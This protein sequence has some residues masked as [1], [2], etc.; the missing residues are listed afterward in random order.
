MRGVALGTEA[1]RIGRSPFPRHED[2]SNHIIDVL[3]L[4]CTSSIRPLVNLVE[5]ANLIQGFV[6][7]RRGEF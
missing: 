3:L 7:M 5:I 2:D 4:N 1:G 6:G